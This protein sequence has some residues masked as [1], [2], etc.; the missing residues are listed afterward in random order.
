MKLQALL[1]GGINIAACSERSNA[2]ALRIG[3][4]DA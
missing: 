3:F 1:E 2:K 4:Y